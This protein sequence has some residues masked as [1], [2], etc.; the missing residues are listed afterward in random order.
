MIVFQSPAAPV[1]AKANF[2]KTIVKSGLVK[3][4]TPIE[5]RHTCAIVDE[6]SGEIACWGEVSPFVGP[7]A[8][9]GDNRVVR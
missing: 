7:A 4:L 9:G 8:G 3:N 1:A 6:C 5:G 2:E